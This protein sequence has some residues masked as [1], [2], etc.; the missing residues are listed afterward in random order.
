VHFFIISP[1][2]FRAEN[3]PDQGL[4]HVQLNEGAHIRYVQ[5]LGRKCCSRS[6]KSAIQ[7][8]KRFQS[9]EHRKIFQ[10]CSRGNFGR[11]GRG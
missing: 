5:D 10:G 2:S 6:G 1:L 11:E 7:Q 3:N 8:S 4:S 9:R